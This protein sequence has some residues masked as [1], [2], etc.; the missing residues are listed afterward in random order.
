MQEMVKQELQEHENESEPNWS[1]ATSFSY[2]V[3]I[4]QPSCTSADCVIRCARPDWQGTPTNIPDDS[5]TSSEGQ[6]DEAY[7]LS[8]ESDA[9]RPQPTRTSLRVTLISRKPPK[10]TLRSA[11]RPKTEEAKPRTSTRSSMA[12]WLADHEEE[13]TVA[14][15]Q[16]I[17]STSAQT[18][19]Q[20]ASSNSAQ[21]LDL[22][23]Q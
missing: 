5:S 21:T 7:N 15:S 22:S 19:D 11:T 23:A 10:P 4:K 9:D 12:S 8:E 18:L 2:H 20:P 1:M 3:R 17:P 16:P 14:S 6:Q 13:Q